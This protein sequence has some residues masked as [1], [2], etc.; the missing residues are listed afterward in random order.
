M[1]LSNAPALWHQVLHGFH[2]PGLLAII[3][4]PAVAINM[5]SLLV[6]R[7]LLTRMATYWV[8]NNWGGFSAIVRRGLLATVGGLLPQWL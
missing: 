2:R 4:M 6:F 3:Y 1:Y 5:L 7:P 8:E